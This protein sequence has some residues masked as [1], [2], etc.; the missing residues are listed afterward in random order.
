MFCSLLA[1]NGLWTARRPPQLAFFGPPPPPI[2]IWVL[3]F[4]SF[5]CYLFVVWVGAPPMAMPLTT[6][7]AKLMRRFLNTIKLGSVLAHKPSKLAARF[8]V[9]VLEQRER[10]GH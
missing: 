2:L 10:D 7:G 3:R 9:A 4:H 5:V 6:I 8:L 1:K